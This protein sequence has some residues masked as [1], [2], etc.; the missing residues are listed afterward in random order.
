MTKIL[1]LFLLLS[2]SVLATEKP[3]LTIYTYDAFS[4]SW[5]PAPKIKKAF[6]KAHNVTLKFVGLSSSIGALRKIQLE[7]K[8]TKADILLGLDTS[9]AEVA[10][11]TGL[12]VPHELN[13]STLDLPAPYNDDTFTPFDYS[14]F[15]FVYDENR[16]KNV[17]DSFESLASMPKDFKI[18]IQDPRSSTAGLGLLLWIK[19]IY[20]DKAGAYWKRLA[21][22]ILTITKGWSEA[23]GLFLK[24]EADMVLSY[25][26]SPAYH[27]V[28]E[29]KTNIKA[30]KF[31]EGHYGQIE[32]A[33]VLK[34]SKHQALAKAFLAFMHTKTFADIIPTANWAYPVV[35]GAKLPK[36]FETLVHPREMI[37]MDGVSVEDRRKA[38]VGEWLRAIAK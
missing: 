11:K 12:F 7:G 16:L 13:T 9:I 30:A 15:A 27:I 29:H 31:K 5:G 35:K 36:A 4:A 19:S 1:Q 33:A 37:L 10:K 3:T 32:V 17:P 6:E 23:Y 28:E 24:G 8:R 2:L 25:T 26:T 20:G 18:V 22:H 21:P 38:I 14:Y 34:S